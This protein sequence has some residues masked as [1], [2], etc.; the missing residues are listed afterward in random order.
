MHILYIQGYNLS[1]IVLCPNQPIVEQNV[2]IFFKLIVLL[3]DKGVF[4]SIMKM[5]FCLQYLLGDCRYESNNKHLYVL[6]KI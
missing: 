4:E 5:I 1:I 6:L 3:I 2:L